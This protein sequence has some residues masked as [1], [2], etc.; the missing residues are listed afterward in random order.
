[1]PVKIGKGELMYEVHVM[2]HDYVRS[3]MYG[4]ETSWG[5]DTYQITLR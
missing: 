1:M 4:M 5:L 3:Q 2:S